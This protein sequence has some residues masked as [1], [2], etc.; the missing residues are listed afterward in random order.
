L[1]SLISVVMEV[2]GE[3]EEEEEEKERA[4]A[5]RMFIRPTIQYRQ[6]GYQSTSAAISNPTDSQ[7]ECGWHADTDHCRG[8]RAHA[9]RR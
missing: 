6:S 1:L 5:S 7:L 4:I 8:H 2:N 3:E 9:K